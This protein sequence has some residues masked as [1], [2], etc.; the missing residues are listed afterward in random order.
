MVEVL[1]DSGTDISAVGTDILAHLNED[2]CNL[3]SSDVKPRAVNGN[4]ISPI[5]SLKVIIGIGGRSV[6]DHF[7]IYKPISWALL[8]W[9]TA[10][11]LGILPTK[12]VHNLINMSRFIRKVL[13]L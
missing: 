4:I 7:H 11:Q 1:P 2:I 13:N 6:E 5:G 10:K 12:T 9:K 3:L 8:Y